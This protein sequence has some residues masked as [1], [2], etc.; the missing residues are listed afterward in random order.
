M[1]KY[2]QHELCLIWLDSFMGLEYKRKLELYKIIDGKNNIKE[3]LEKNAEYIRKVLRVN[4]YQTLINSASSEYLDGVLKV[5]ESKGVTCVTLFS[6][7][8]PTLL[9]QTEIPPLVL[10]AKG[11]IT[12]LGS[13]CVS[14]VGSRKAL[15]LS[16]KIAENYAKEIA[17]AKLTLVTGIAQGVDQTVISSA[18]KNGGKVISVLASGID[19]IY[20]KSNHALVESVVKN[21]LVISEYPPETLSQKYFYPIRNRIIA[22]LS[23]VT[24]IINGGIKSGTRYTAH[25]ALEYGREVFAVPYSVGIESGAGNIDLLKNGA[26]VTDTP[27]DI[28]D[29]YGIAK[30]EDRKVDLTDQEKAI[31]KI[32]SSEQ[33][34]VE[35]LAIQLNKKVFEITP[36]LSMLEL[37][38]VIIKNGINSYAV[39]Q[40]YLEE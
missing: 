25:Y 31:V 32:L 14:M 30:A 4:E 35:K 17:K 11:D 40:N 26:F 22:G 24:V 23:K 2:D 33:I 10:Y 3:V 34:T 39:C 18:L 38:G 20:P 36:K 7:D 9:K 27:D 1:K 8:Y 28:L 21:G 6:K 16:I 19:N 15:P 5:L 13:A 12:L 29:A 37:K